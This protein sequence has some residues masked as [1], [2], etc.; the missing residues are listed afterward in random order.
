MNKVT[1]AVAGSRKTQSIVDACTDGPTTRRRLA[2]TYTLTG[3]AE[4][5]SR[6]QAASQPGSMTEVMGWYAFL[7]RHWVRPFLPLH[8]PNRRL[9][10]LNF[11][12]EPARGWYTTCLLY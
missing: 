8:F 2:L 6:L 3:Q 7:M 12:G 9:R 4:L 1:L 5:T 10:G 11:D